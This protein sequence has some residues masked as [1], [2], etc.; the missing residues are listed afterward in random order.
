MEK[1]RITGIKIN[2]YYVCKRKLWLFSH[3]I[4]MEH[5]SE[6][7][8]IGKIIHEKKYERKR[9]EIRLDGIK[10]DFFEANKGIIHEIKKSKSINIAHKTQLKYYLWY[11]KNIGIEAIG[12]LDYPEI[13]QKETIELKEND[14]KEIEQIITDIE[15]IIS[16]KSPPDVINSKICKKCSYYDLCYM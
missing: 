5:T 8:E 13:R 14:V 3:N 9:K 4:T 6:N 7:V 10:I 1:P 2:Y 11:F 12:S 16:E 15:K